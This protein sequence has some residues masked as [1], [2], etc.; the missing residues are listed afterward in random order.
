MNTNLLDYSGESIEAL[1]V[2]EWTPRTRQN[3]AGSTDITSDAPQN[4]VPFRFGSYSFGIS[5]PPEWSY[6][7][8]SKIRNLGGLQANWDSYNSERIAPQCAKRVIDLVFLTLDS[9][10]PMPSIVPTNRGGIQLEWHREGA[11]LEI[12]IEPSLSHIHV[13]FED[14]KSCEE[15]EL[16]LPFNDYKKLERFLQR[17]SS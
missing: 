16:S 14:Q 7:M 1:S 11:D 9:T 5:K 12:E 10:T 13:Y 4:L 2:G 15:Q 17:I 8:L 3:V 6:G